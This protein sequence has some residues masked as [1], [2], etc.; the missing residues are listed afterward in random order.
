[1]DQLGLKC[2]ALGRKQPYDNAPMEVERWRLAEINLA[3][4]LSAMLKSSTPPEHPA[5]TVQ[6]NCVDQQLADKTD[7][8][9]SGRQL[10]K[11]MMEHFE[12]SIESTS[13]FSYEA[14]NALRWNGDSASLIT[15]F[16]WGYKAL[17]FGLPCKLPR[18]YIAQMLFS[19]MAQ[20]KKLEMELS[21]LGRE[22]RHSK[23]LP[24][25]PKLAEL[26]SILVD[27]IERANS[28]LAN[29]IAPFELLEPISG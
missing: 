20:S 25:V 6:H 3:T 12:S 1:M 13:K 27:Q 18:Q 10:I 22:I 15:L 8:V 7:S 24:P 29:K 11:L 5:L 23:R 14:V 21:L 2:I 9:I 16:Y 19:Q 17:M 26:E 4:A 28:R